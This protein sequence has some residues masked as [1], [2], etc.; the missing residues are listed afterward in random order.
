MLCFGVLGSGFQNFG[1]GGFRYKGIQVAGHWR[2][3]NNFFVAVHVL[4][5]SLRGHLALDFA[6]DKNRP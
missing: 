6:A 1:L 4:S 3:Q 2:L 5:V